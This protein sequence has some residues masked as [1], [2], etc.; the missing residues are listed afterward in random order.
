MYTC[1]IIITVEAK[2]WKLLAIWSDE[3]SLVFKF[4]KFVVIDVDRI[5]N[6]EITQK[7]YYGK[8]DMMVNRIH[9]YS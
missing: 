1:Y 2:V 8:I 6:A 4:R 5:I 3:N 7:N 9:S